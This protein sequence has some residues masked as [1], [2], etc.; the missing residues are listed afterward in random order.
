MSINNTFHKLHISSVN[1]SRLL[2]LLLLCLSLHA[3]AAVKK[4]KAKSKS[5]VYSLTV[6]GIRPENKGD[7]FVR[8]SF[9]QSARFYKLPKDA[10]PE[11]LILLKESEKSHKPVMVERA[12]ETSDVIISVTKPK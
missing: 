12:N 3:C 4:H 8:V 7:T 1:A 2:S 9:L 5:V 6:A 10:N 11:Y